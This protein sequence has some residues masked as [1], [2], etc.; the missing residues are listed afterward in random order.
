VAELTLFSYF[1]GR[2]ILH[3]FDPRLKMAVVLLLSIAV[4][5]TRGAGLVLVSLF[6]AVLTAV[7]GY[8][9]LGRGGLRRMRMVLVLASIIVIGRT[10]FSVSADNGRYLF[11]WMN[12][13]TVE[14]LREG[15]LG[16]WRLLLFVC[17]GLLFTVTTSDVKI[18]DSIASILKPVPFIPEQKLAIM[19][20]LTIT[21]VPVILNKAREISEVH[22]SRAIM[23][24]KKP[25]RR[26]IKYAGHL[27]TAVLKQTDEI[28]DAFESRAFS[29]SRT[30]PYFNMSGKD[31]LSA[32]LFIAMLAGA[33]IV[34]RYCA[35]YWVL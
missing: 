24:S 17:A 13:G 15:V 23:S 18:R 30:P 34:D 32:V 11:P 10:F 29:D 14:G 22:A 20:G 9:L 16:A 33:V 5:M 3:Q 28:T 21:F 4:F 6:A 35:G 26:F 7:S 19:M 1:P 27:M 25:I 31:V 12:F 2:S 8:P